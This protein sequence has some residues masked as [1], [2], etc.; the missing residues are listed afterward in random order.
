MRIA[1]VCLDPGVP[2]FG[3]KGCSI[4]VQEVVRALR[5]LGLEVVLF[6]CRRGGV[7]APDLADLEVCDLP[8]EFASRAPSDPAAREI[9]AVRNN[10]RLAAALDRVGPFDLVYERYS[11][12]SYGAM[13]HARDRQIPSVLEVN[14]P[15]I[16][17]QATQR[18]LVHSSL[19]QVCSERAF[20]AASALVAVSNEVAEYLARI[21]PA[22]DKISVVA[23]GVNIRRFAE[24]LEGSGSDRPFT[25]GFVGTLKPWHGT[26][27]LLRSFRE[28]LAI[29]EQARL[30][31]VG[32]GPQREPLNH[33]ARE[34]GIDAHVTFTGSVAPDAIP[35][36]L[37][38]M[39]VAVAP[40]PN[41]EGFYFSPLKVYEYMAASLPVVASNL[42]QLRSLIEHGRNGL[43]VPPGDVSHLT[44]ALLKL[45]AD[46]G[47]RKRLGAAGWQ[48]V[49]QHHT[50]RSVAKRILSIASAASVNLASEPISV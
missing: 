42:G 13:E 36:L 26:D 1:Y 7:P 14:A 41:L 5:Q 39:D 33:L 28:V 3:Q 47:L 27:L 32:N 11:L 29:T 4:H 35:G 31:I 50:W 9:G 48:T 19:A 8:I 34:L 17:E 46:A 12:W 6:A 10:L 30:L 40:Y 18:T 43:L 20:A 38:R 2:V 24:A 16:E 45:H 37:G 44:A 23:N 15:L 21:E 22:Q 49:A 25:I